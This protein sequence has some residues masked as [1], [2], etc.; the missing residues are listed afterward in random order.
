[1]EANMGMCLERVINVLLR[2]TPSASQSKTLIWR[3]TARKRRIMSNNNNNTPTKQRGKRQNASAIGLI[4]GSGRSSSRNKSKK[5]VSSPRKG[6]NETVN[7][8]RLKKDSAR[9]NMGDVDKPPNDSET[10]GAGTPT[11]KSTGA[12]VD[13]SKDS[14]NQVSKGAGSSTGAPHDEAAN[15]HASDAS[16]DATMKTSGGQAAT[17][18][19]PTESTETLGDAEESLETSL[20]MTGHS[21]PPPSALAAP[22]PSIVEESVLGEMQSVDLRLRDSS[23]QIHQDDR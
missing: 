15:Q 10:S 1:M 14:A 18:P 3:G 8:E 21:S 7:R 13:S 4:F 19:P 12:E 20:T 16:A 6:G 22:A 2:V 23:V 9:V 11:E 5:G 17:K